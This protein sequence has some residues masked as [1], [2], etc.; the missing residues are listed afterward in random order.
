MERCL[1]ALGIADVSGFQD[2]ALTACWLIVDAL[3]Y[4]SYDSVANAVNSFNQYTSPQ[5]FANI[6]AY[7]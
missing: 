5:V 6:N 4:A 2:G 3:D 1:H 7:T